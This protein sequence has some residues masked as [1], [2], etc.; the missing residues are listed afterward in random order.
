[1]RVRP[2]TSVSLPL[3]RSIAAVAQVRFSAN[4]LPKALGVLSCND[5]QSEEGAMWASEHSAETSAK[6]EGIWR[7]WTDVAAWPEW[8]SDIERIELIGPFAVGSKILMTPV[9]DEPIELR[10][11]DVEEP[12]LFVDE[13]DLGE[14]VVRTIHQ[15]RRIDA[16]RARVTYRIEITGPDSDTLGPQLGPEISGDFPD[17]LAG[18]VARAET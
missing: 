8:N 5:S 13:A 12:E 18:L 15:A 11:A 16:D 3:I 10:I 7:I 14:I 6:P 2:R 4:L 17:V 9:G 1:M